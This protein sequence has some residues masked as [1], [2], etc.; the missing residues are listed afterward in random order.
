MYFR[1]A[2]FDGNSK[3]VKFALG[4]GYRSFNQETLV[5]EMVKREAYE[6]LKIFFHYK[7]DVPISL[8]E[9][10]NK[11]LSKLLKKYYPRFTDM[12]ELDLERITERI[13]KKILREYKLPDWVIVEKFTEEIRNRVEF[14]VKDAYTNGE[15]SIDA[16]EFSFLLVPRDTDVIRCYDYSPLQTIDFE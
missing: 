6:I 4:H 16:E 9:T 3:F 2:C 11:I 13:T 14:L 12:P 5:S 8:K 10:K 1:Q 15:T 7:L